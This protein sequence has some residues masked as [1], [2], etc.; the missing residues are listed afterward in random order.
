MS[1]SLQPGERYG[2]FE[3]LEELGEGGFGRVYKVID[4]RYGVPMAL[5]LSRHPV[6]ELET[7]QRALREVAVLRTMTNPHVV[8]VYDAGLRRDGNI[9]VLMELLSGRPLD[10]CGRL[11]SIAAAEVIGHVGPRPLVDLRTLL[12]DG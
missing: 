8:R 2:P 5:K 12:G 1:E 9:Y 11:G 7:A 10:E 3:I 4:P 6:T